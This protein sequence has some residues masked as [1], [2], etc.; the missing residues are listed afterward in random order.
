[1]TPPLSAGPLTKGDGKLR[2][3]SSHFFDVRAGAI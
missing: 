2:V 1:M 3:G